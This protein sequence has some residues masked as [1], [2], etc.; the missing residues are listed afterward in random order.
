ML[1]RIQI[2]LSVFVMVS[3]I[4]AVGA[5]LHINE[6]TIA[7]VQV[8]Q[9]DCCMIT[10]PGGR[11]ILIDSGVSEETSDKTPIAKYCSVNGIRKIDAAFVSHYHEDHVGGM[12]TLFETAK[13]DVLLLPTPVS[14][15]DIEYKNKLLTNAKGAKAYYFQPGE[16]LDLG[17]ALKLQALYFNKALEDSANDNCMV[18]RVTCMGTS[19]LFTGDI[20]S[21][22]EAD[23]V[24]HVPTDLLKS[25]IIKVAHHGS[26]Y[27][28]S[29]MF[30]QTVQPKD[31]VICVGKNTFGHPSEEA[32]NRILNA[33]AKIHR[34][35][36]DG[37]VKI[38]ITKE[39]YSFQ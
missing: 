14:D 30:Y 18:M 1:K 2:V 12:V 37:T 23:I 17:D 15:E 28:S 20:G 31:A 21:E 38:A 27:S 10:T 29:D 32:M 5:I 3:V 11:H 6:Y 35:D 24:N 19:L 33:G 7:F 36:Q 4:Y 26:K 13:C 25:D 9:G 16:S 34:T 39:G 8:G 22:M